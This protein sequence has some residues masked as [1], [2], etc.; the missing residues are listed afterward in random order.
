MKVLIIG[1][2]KL[3]YMPYINFYLDNMDKIKNVVHILY[4][5]RDQN[6]ENTT[7]YQWTT[8][9]EFSFYQ[10]DE[11]AKQHKLKGF[12]EYRKF[13]IK[14]LS[15]EKFDFIIVLDTLPGILIFDKLKQYYSNRY[16][17]DYRD[18]TYEENLIFRKVIHFVVRHSRFTF[19]SSDA[20]RK[21]LPRDSNI[22]TSHNILMDSLKHRN[23]KIEHNILSD[24]IRIAFWGIIRDEIINK[25]II[26][27]LGNDEQFELHY[28]GREQKTA[29]NLKQYIKEM[30]ITN[31]FF[32][33]EYQPEDRYE[34][35]RR[36]DLI[37]NIYCDNNTM[38]AMGNKYYDG[39]IFYLPQLCMKGSF[40]GERVFKN[41]VG[42][43][44]DPSEENFS[45]TVSAYY[46]KIDRTSFESACDNA[47]LCILSEY[48]NGKKI[49]SDFIK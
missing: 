3:K 48:N 27:K 43:S 46:K 18:S 12:L 21:Y 4:W 13:I 45:E 16:I 30:S 20:F 26:Q 19:V 14:T 44:C 39:I 36:T 15:D 37:H 31:V 17:L 28:Y 47:L 38:L 35:V 24:K 2:S 33:G 8:L 25:E 7:A 1:S 29:L 34:F 49:I 40:M 42:I 11:V 41:G 23:E 6:P 22:Y 10:K 9:H 5:N 32:H